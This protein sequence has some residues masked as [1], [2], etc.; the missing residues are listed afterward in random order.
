MK[1]AITALFLVTVLNINAQNS[2]SKD[3]NSLLIFEEGFES[4][5]MNLKK[6]G[7]APEVV[8]MSNARAGKYVMKSQIYPDKEVKY[9]TEVS[10]NQEGLLFEV[11]KEYWVGMS[12]MLG[13]D[14]NDTTSIKDQGMLFQWH[15]FDWKYPKELGL[16]QPQP[17]LL[18]YVGNGQAII[19][20]EVLDMEGTAPGAMAKLAMET[21]QWVDWVI[22]Y[23]LDNEEGIIQVWRNKELVVDWTGDNHQVEKQDGAYFKFGLYSAQFKKD[24]LPKGHSRTVYHDEVRIA[25]ENGSY[26]MVAPKS[27]Q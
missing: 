22:H 25:G 9:R 21:G 24:P 18:R 15:Y 2:I 12:T 20:S 8:K 23:K 16:G 14:F 11:G 6:S 26:E 17:L 13:E 1:K 7:N 19:Q 10:L 4:G 3:A 5:Q 27:K